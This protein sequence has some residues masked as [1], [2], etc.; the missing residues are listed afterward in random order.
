MS[1][2]QAVFQ[3][4]TPP[5]PM[6]HDLA[7][8]SRAARVIPGGMW[9]HMS[10]KRLPPAFPQFFKSAEGTRL[11]D[12]DGNTYIDFMCAYGPMILGYNDPD[13]ESAVNAQQVRMGIANGPG[14]AMVDLAELM[15]EMIP[16]ADWA[17]FAKNGTDAT[18]AC[19]SIARAATKKRKILVATGAYHGAVPWCTP[20]PGGV[21]AEDRAHLICYAYNDVASLEAAAEE[22][23]N[24]LAGIIASAFR[25]DARVDQEMPTSQFAG[26]VRAMADRN[27]AVLILDDVRAGFRLNLG[28]SWEPLGVQPDLSAWSKALGNGH[29][30]AAITGREWLRE[31]V[32]N[33]YV[34]GSFWYAAAPMVAAMTTLQKL[35]RLDAVT[36]MAR[37][38]QKLRDGIADQAATHGIGIRQTGP[39]QMPLVLFDND[40][41][42]EKGYLFTTTALEHGVYLHPWH[43]MF[44]SA[45][46]NTEDIDR[47]LEGTN[48][49]FKAVADV[50]G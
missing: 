25:H 49:G 31:A 5:K 6:P 15:V 16:A 28:G 27:N 42:L 30:I 33:V 29:P 23:G 39:A 41:E 34:T 24:D 2:T 43:N 45:A 21:V 36:H 37:L 12:V 48:A 13:V 10:A 46:H 14:E 4:R 38:G 44:L 50:C 47:A 11:T 1:E 26:A 35:R 18:T 7:L 19:V 3:N 20:W 17:M 9:G 32:Q 8:R 40:D 22:A